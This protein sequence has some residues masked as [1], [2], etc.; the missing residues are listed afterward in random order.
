MAAVIPGLSLTEIQEIISNLGLE[1]LD[2]AVL[3]V[4][5]EK[6]QAIED[7]INSELF[8]VA[9]AEV[10]TILERIVV[11]SIVLGRDIILEPRFFVG[12]GEE[13]NLNGS[14]ISPIVVNQGRIFD[15]GLLGDNI[16]SGFFNNEGEID[17][18]TG[19]DLVLAITGGLANSN[20]LST[21][22]GVD[23]ISGIATGSIRVDG[24]LNEGVLATGGGG[25]QIIGNAL[26]LRDVDGIENSGGGTIITGRGDDLIDGEAEGTDGVGGINN[27]NSGVIRTG[28]GEDRIFG[29][30][31]DLTG[32]AE[33]GEMSGIL[34]RG[35]PL[36]DAGAGEDLEE[37][38]ALVKA[39]TDSGRIAGINN[40]GSLITL[41]AGEDAL[42]GEALAAGATSA[43]GIFNLQAEIDAGA[44]E[45]FVIGVA[46]TEG[47]QTV[48][49]VA[50]VSSRLRLGSG[51]DVIE[52]VATGGVINAGI[53]VDQNSVINAGKGEDSLLGWG[54]ST[55][56]NSAITNQGVIKMGRGSDVVDAF[57]GGF[58]G[59]GL[60]SL[61][62][63]D[64]QLVGFGTGFFDGGRG[65]DTLQLA[66]GEYVFD[67]AAGTL[68]SGGVTMNLAS[69]EQIG[70]VADTQFLLLQ[71]GTYIVNAEN[72]IQFA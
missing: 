43:S 28:F 53:F 49:G 17:F 3:Q 54:L 4:L 47:G 23:L 58:S 65:L 40:D 2:P 34:N 35:N 39:V 25:D 50:L 31:D 52:G 63:G 6:V 9:P 18:G 21:G 5:L 59:D 16:F 24:V 46:E 36:I 70:G 72:Q 41:G 61:G 22:F 66:E 7:E 30:A 26:G 10:R 38:V 42:I 71:D 48:S 64:D 14:L 33:S 11:E 1:P 57:F 56:D 51:E 27:D 19:Q 37:G 55:G 8:N 13:F 60:T 68:V 20:L 29:L 12:E 67:A 69:I 32:L 62:A 44:G 45:D 15:D